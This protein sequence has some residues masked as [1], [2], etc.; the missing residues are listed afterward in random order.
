MYKHWEDLLEHGK[1]FFTNLENLL[2]D[3]K[4]PRS[5]SKKIYE[6][7]KSWEKFSTCLN[8]FNTFI[9]PVTPEDFNLPK[10]ASEEF[11]KQWDR[12]KKYLQEQHGIIVRSYYQNE[13][14]ERLFDI[15][16]ND[17]KK[18]IEYLKFAM[19]NG[20]R[21]FFVVNEDVKQTN[22]EKNESTKAHISDY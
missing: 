5:M 2:N 6:T 16:K 8:N 10:D 22:I 1:N 19:A 20:Y 14:I 7:T 4:L 18:A 9:T 11:L 21:K 17:P 12:W 15:S 13:S 3:N